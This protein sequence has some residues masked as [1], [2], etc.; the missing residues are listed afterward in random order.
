VHGHEEMA[1]ALGGENGE[2]SRG[3]KR[4]TGLGLEKIKVVV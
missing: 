3:N 1:E 2:A 4:I